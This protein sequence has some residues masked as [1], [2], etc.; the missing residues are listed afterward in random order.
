MKNA[1]KRY[2]RMQRQQP[3]LV[4]LVLIVLGIHLNAHAR[5]HA[6]ARDITSVKESRSPNSNILH[7]RG[8]IEIALVGEPTVL[9]LRPMTR[10]GVMRIVYT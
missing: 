7:P 10:S 8:L 6:H 5:A 1:A 9:P 4:K 2:L 3:R